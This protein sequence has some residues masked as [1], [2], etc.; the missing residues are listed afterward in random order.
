M[1]KE[2]LMFFVKNRILLGL[3]LKVFLKKMKK[4]QKIG[5]K[6]KVELFVFYVF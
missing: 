5:L 6:L 3:N 4:N 1:V 2:S